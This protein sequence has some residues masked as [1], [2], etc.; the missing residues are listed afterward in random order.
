M[1]T[2]K[3][4]SKAPVRFVFSDDVSETTITIQTDDP[5]EVVAAKLRRV[6]ELEGVTAGAM[7]LNNVKER[8]AQTPEF[9]PADRAAYDE[10]MTQA[11]PLGWGEGVDIESLPEA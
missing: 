8:L 1:I 4:G 9:T 2:M 6:L 7:L 3:T 5:S 11:Q 10:R